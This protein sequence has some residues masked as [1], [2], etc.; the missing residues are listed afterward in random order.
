VNE[1]RLYKQT[2]KKGLMY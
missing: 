2:T 1:K